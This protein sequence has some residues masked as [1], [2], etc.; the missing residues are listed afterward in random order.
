[1]SDNTRLLMDKLGIWVS[2]LCALH[3]LALPLLLP[4]APLIASSFVAEAWF[5]RTI[6]S[7]SLLVGLAALSVG[8]I[9]YHRQIMPALAL[10][11]GGLIYWNKDILG[12]AFEPITI[13][14]GASLIIA[15]HV[16]NLRLCRAHK[17][18]KRTECEAV[19]SSR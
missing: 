19:L 13:A 3:C 9:R 4:I 12:E 10:F 1:M 5:E 15:A 18:A 8:Y 11:T 17:I 16:M 14:M 7:L 2:G 6:L